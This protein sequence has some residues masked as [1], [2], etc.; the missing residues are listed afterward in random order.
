MDLEGKKGEDMDSLFEG[1][2]L[3]NPAEEKDNGSDD[4]LTISS[5]SQS[6]PLDENLFS[7][8]TLVV[9][10]LQNLE[11]AEAERDLQ[12]RQGHAPARR[13]KRS[14]LRIGY[15]RDAFSSNDP[16]HTPSPLPQPISDSDSVGDADAVRV[17]DTDTDTE[18]LPS[19][20]TATATATDDPVTVTLTQPSNESENQNRKHQQ[21]STESS[22]AEFRQLKSSIHDKLNHATQ[23]VKS[24]SSARKDSIR[25]RR[26]T[27]ENA[28]LAS[29]KHMELEKQLEEACEAEDF[30]RA[31]KVSDDLSAAEKEKQAFANSLREADAFVDALDLKLQ[32]ALDSQLAIE[33]QCAILLDH[34]ATNAL[35][36]A[37]FS[38]KKA[39]SVYSKEMDQW[40][41][42]S[43]ALEV[44]KME[45][46]IESQFMNEARLELNNTIEHSI[47]NDKRE[48]EILCK[49]KDVLMGELEQL[50]A[51]V[52]QKEMEIAD[53]DSNLEAVEN[54]IN[55]VV[56]G[57][58]EMQSSIDV[59]YD[60]LQSVLAQVKLETETLVLK[61]EE[62]DN[63]LI[64]EEEMGARLREFVRISTEEAEGYRKIVKLRRSLMSS[65]L[66][67][68]EDKLTLS[69]KE[70]KLSGDVKLFQQ[71]VSAARAS[72][73]EL[74]SRKSSI[75]QDIA[76]FKQ[77]I[78]FIDKRVPELEA[79][80]KVATT[81]R[82]FKEAARIATEAKSLCVEKESIQINMDMAT[83]NLEKLEEEINDTLNKLQ[84]TEGM[85]LLKEKELAMVR[86]QKLLLA[87][88]T[89]R[90]EKAAAVEMGDVEE[91][92]LLLAEAEAADC[93]A[94]KLKS[95]YKFEAEDF[96][97][98]QRHLISMDLVSHLD[99]KQLEE[100]AVSLRLFTG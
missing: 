90:A 23:L 63:F 40:L 44:K 72:L 12:S 30:E 91:A 67:S 35:N 49:R 29:L 34:Y 8:L 69:K 80:K 22:S 60:K 73:Q 99:Q 5:C 71:E 77:R 46:E 66:K 93:D 32:H 37:D 68:R 18:T 79:E 70:E 9:D 26:K 52:K 92:N 86:Y 98:L 43:E 42:S 3:F 58:K 14:G 56:S 25:N 21:S 78:V 7:D 24:A 33:E 15:G 95:T 62:I 45:L 53:N 11:V 89:A 97:D 82:N 84:E 31:E 28:N 17:R 81:A 76:S 50:L 2:V 94:E 41:S 96:T 74:S 64:R 39:S 27:V 4:S 65:I 88:A 100:L 61:K 10:P 85:I 48:K 13:R 16:P 1:M 19:I 6:Q 83:L 87:A 36:N 47:Q 57:F 59:K 54:K 20:T 75:Q 51:L 38:M 55:K